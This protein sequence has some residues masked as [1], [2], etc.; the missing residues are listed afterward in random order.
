VIA[1]VDSGAQVSILSEECAKRCNVL[2]LA[3][4]RFRATAV[5]VGGTQKFIGRN[6][7]D[8]RF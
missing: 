5:G 4:K 8:L 6:N 7:V 3:D 2:R 1:F